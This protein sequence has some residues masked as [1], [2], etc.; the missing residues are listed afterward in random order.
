MT[1]FQKVQIEIPHSTKRVRSG[2]HDRVNLILNKLGLAIPGG[3]FRKIRFASED[4]AFVRDRAQ[5]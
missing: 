2:N 4:K 1:I 3:L 5:R